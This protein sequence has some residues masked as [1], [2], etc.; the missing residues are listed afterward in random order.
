MFLM[1]LHWIMLNQKYILSSTQEGIR[2]LLQILKTF[3]LDI[4]HKQF[5]K[6]IASGLQIP[7]ASDIGMFVP[8]YKAMILET[9]LSTLA[10]KSLACC[11]ALSSTQFKIFN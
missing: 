3:S 7:L 1:A 4:R 8:L 9:K 5:W 6:Y 11:L 2:C 10:A